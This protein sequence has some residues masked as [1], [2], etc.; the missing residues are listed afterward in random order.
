[1]I[2]PI[3]LTNSLE[4]FI[5][6]GIPVALS[7]KFHWC[8]LPPRLLSFCWFWCKHSPNPPMP[9]FQ[10]FGIEFV[11]WPALLLSGCHYLRWL[12]QSCHQSRR[13][14]SD[15]LHRIYLVVVSLNQFD[16]LVPPQL[17]MCR[18]LKH[19]MMHRQH[20]WL[21]ALVSFDFSH[22]GKLLQNN[23]WFH[24][25]CSFSPCWA[26]LTVAGQTSMSTDRTNSR[27][28]VISCWSRSLPWVLDAFKRCIRVLIRYGICHS[29]L[30]FQL[31]LDTHLYV[32]WKFKSFVGCPCL[33]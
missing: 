24:N 26:F 9:L 19:L 8:S 27:L 17:H 29:F 30:Y 13:N 10:C 20:Y 28:V 2:T 31:D 1:M 25:F 14:L 33:L 4:K 18:L 7:S 11:F 12:L 5:A 21:L 6:N 3:V 15:S 32:Y 23:L 22:C 16:S